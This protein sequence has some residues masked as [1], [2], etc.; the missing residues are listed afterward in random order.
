MGAIFIVVLEFALRLDLSRVFLAGFALC[1]LA[2][3]CLFR[4][5]SG[6]LLGMVR[7]E[8]GAPNYVVVVGTG[9][10]A[11]HIARQIEEAAAYGIRLRGFLSEPGEPAP[12]QI[13]LGSIYP[14][15]PL[16]RLAAMLREH[17]I[18]EVVF[19]VDSRQLSGLEDV[20]LMCDEEGVRTRVAV[21][22][23]PHV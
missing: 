4:L 5:N 12:E 18:D 10:P 9:A 13:E 8:F 3:S 6:R 11:L 19:A 23:F 2:L 17:V 20:F 21:D 1:N 15:Q 14:V 7:R 22:F 16:S